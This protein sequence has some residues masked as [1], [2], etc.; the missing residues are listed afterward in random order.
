MLVRRSA[1]NSYGVLANSSGARDRANLAGYLCPPPASSQLRCSARPCAAGIYRDSACACSRG[2]YSSSANA[3]TNA[4][5]PRSNQT[6][7]SW[8]RAA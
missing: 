3:S 6:K 7:R 5:S 8:L 2:V 4:S 1:R